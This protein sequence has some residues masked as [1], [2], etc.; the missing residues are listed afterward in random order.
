MSN[1]FSTKINSES[2]EAGI[3]FAFLQ[4]SKS[5]PA[6]NSSDVETVTN[7]SAPSESLELQ[8]SKADDLWQQGNISEAIALY[9]QAIEQQPN[10]TEL[11]GHLLAVV[12]Q[13][14]ELATA[15]TKLAE[16]LKQKGK[17]KEAA[18]YYRQAIVLKAINDRAQKNYQKNQPNAIV[19]RPKSQIK[20]S[21]DSAFS[22]LP[23]SSQSSK[24]QILQISLD[25]DFKIS[26]RH[27]QNANDPKKRAKLYLQE[28]LNYGDRQEWEEAARACQKALDLAPDLAAA[29][30]ILGNALQRMGKTAAAMDCYAK[31]LEIQPD[32]AEVYAKIGSL[33]S[34]QEQWQPALEYYQKAIVIRPNF[35]QAYRSLAEIWSLVGEVAKAE[36]CRQQALSIESSQLNAAANETQTSKVVAELPTA[37]TTNNTVIEY[38][39]LAQELEKQQQ[40]QEAALYYRKALEF[41]LSNSANFAT[42][43]TKLIEELSSQKQP[44]QLPP[45]NSHTQLFTPLTD[46]FRAKAETKDV[47]SAVHCA[48]GSTSKPSLSQLDKAINRYLKRTEIQPDSAKLQTDLGNLYAKKRQWQIAIAAY[49]RAIKINDRYAPAYLNLAKILA[50]L[51]KKRESVSYMYRA[52]SLN[53]E[54]LSAKDYFYL[55]KSFIEQ[56]RLRKGLSYCLKAVRLDPNYLE[57]YY[58]LDKV[59]TH[60]GQQ[61]KAINYLYQAIKRNPKDLQAYYLL[62]QTLA[63]QTNWDEAVKA[64]SQVLQIQPK[65]PL[66]SEKLNHALAEKLKQQ[67]QKINQINSN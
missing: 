63:A 13:Q 58:H 19:V 41:N 30:K 2:G 54:I 29:Y 7:E 33:Y 24:P 4:K 16:Q 60:K 14:T 10:A 38:Q 53:P 44:S 67:K 42:S 36:S 22:F 18:L 27:H 32:L 57:V 40:W 23:L 48:A 11:Y 5:H 1:T 39:K 45:Q 26:A 55:G 47:S 66:A 17:T 62:G 21:V 28:A 12:R 65:F 34:Q 8:L 25:N 20:V 46:D 59:I 37:T 6:R 50:K 61:Q 49:Q 15:Y 43:E 52:L 64:Y 31:A 9:C 51:G 3:G 56:D 35:A